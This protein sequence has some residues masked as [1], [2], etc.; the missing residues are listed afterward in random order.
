M[1]CDC[2]VH[3][4]GAADR[5]PQIAT[6]TYLAEPAPVEELQRRGATR[7]VS[8]FVLVQPS[9]YG[10]DNTLLLESLDRLGDRG[11]GVAVIDPAATTGGTLADHARR[12][13]RGLRLNLYS[14]QA[15]RA[16]RRLDDALAPL[17]SVARTMHWH[18]ELIT[19]IDVIADNADLLAEAGVPIV[20]DHYGVYGRS[21]P[22]SA[23]GRRLLDLLRLPHVW[24]KLSAPYRVSDDPLNTRPDAAWLAAILSRS[25]DR[26]VWGSDWPHTPLHELQGD[27]AA[28]LPYRNLSYAALVDDF[29][30]ATGSSALAEQI[31]RDNAA[32]LYG[33]PPLPAGAESGYHPATR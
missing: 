18:V 22:E 13:V 32:R 6:R 15:G 26:C 3:I 9:F 20:I 11:R 19:S 16:V 1:R 14:S 5:Y 25:A 7:G 28:A 21:R 2:H 31:M 4:V 17:A 29:L 27:G 10:T 33:F 24:M 30:A 8:R 23:E 12:G